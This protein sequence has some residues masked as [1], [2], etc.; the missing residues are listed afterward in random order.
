[1]GCGERRA[2]KT[3]RPC[4]RATRAFC[5]QKQ[6][7]GKKCKFAFV[8]RKTPLYTGTVPSSSLAIELI[9]SFLTLPHAA[10]NQTNHKKKPDTS[11][12]KTLTRLG[13]LREAPLPDN[14]SPYV[15]PA[16]I[17][18][19]LDGALFFGGFL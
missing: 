3:R 12:A 17:M 14:K 5:A 18:Y 6:P 2:E 15:Q 4:R 1:M 19:E 9:H 7:H 16:A 10:S 13:S 11:M 8:R